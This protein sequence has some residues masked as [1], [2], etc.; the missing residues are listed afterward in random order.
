MRAL[1]GNPLLAISI[2]HGALF[3][4]LLVWDCWHFY[5]FTLRAQ[6]FPIACSRF[7]T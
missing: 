4:Q 2:L 5:S 6:I 7:H 3:L 1:E